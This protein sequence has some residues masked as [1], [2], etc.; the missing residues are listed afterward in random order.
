MHSVTRI[1]V[2]LAFILAILLPANA[3]S[4]APAVIAHQQGSFFFE[5]DGCNGE[6]VAL[7]GIYHVTYK[8]QR[9][10]RINV[11]MLLH[12]TGV[13]SQGNQYVMSMTFRGHGDTSLQ[14]PLIQKGTTALV[15]KG[16]A[17]NMLAKLHFRFTA[18]STEIYD[19]EIA[20]RG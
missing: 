14:K 3:A 16:S 9:D 13:D 8:R 17:P 20:C 15:S 10:D 7:E 2:S 1:L 5:A 6:E 19:V 18:E 12:G 4:A 11:L